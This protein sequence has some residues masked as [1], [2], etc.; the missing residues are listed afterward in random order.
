MANLSGCG[1]EPGDYGL[2]SAFD[3]APTVVELHG[4]AD[5]P[6]ISDTSPLSGLVHAPQRMAAE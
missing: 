3:V 1:L 4:E 5:P 6:R 2:H